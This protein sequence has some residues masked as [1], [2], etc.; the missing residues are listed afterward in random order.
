[1]CTRECTIQNVLEKSFAK[2]PGK[3]TGIYGVLY[4]QFQALCGSTQD[5]FVKMCSKHAIL[6]V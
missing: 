3:V 5:H 4:E 6:N 2:E 1:M